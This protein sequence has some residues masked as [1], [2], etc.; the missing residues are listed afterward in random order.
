MGFLKFEILNIL[1]KI[2]FGPFGVGFLYFIIILICLNYQI[3]SK[4]KIISF[5]VIGVL[6]FITYLIIFNLLED[7]SKLKLGILGFSL[8]KLFSIFSFPFFIYF[9]TKNQD[10][11]IKT[12]E[13]T[14]ELKKDSI[15]C[16]EL[17]YGVFFN[18]TD[19]IKR[20]RKDSIDYELIIYKNSERERLCKIRWIDDCSYIREISNNDFSK[21]K[22]GN[23]NS[24]N[25]NMLTIPLFSHHSDKAQLDV[26]TKLE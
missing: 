6:I 21:I 19:T 15:K 3:V 26:V 13:D 25:H 8:A 20:F 24:L 17:K 1:K 18:G 4:N 5:I 11:S 10:N 7:Q 9:T 14:V 23:I 22:I 12:I 2:F 16:L